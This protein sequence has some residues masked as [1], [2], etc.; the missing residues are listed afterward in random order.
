MAGL[1]CVYTVICHVRGTNI[2]NHYI[3]CDFLPVDI[4]LQSV[5]LEFMKLLQI[6]VNCALRVKMDFGIWWWGG[7]WWSN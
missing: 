6:V 1:H 7:W 3:F 2:Y 4:L 5:T